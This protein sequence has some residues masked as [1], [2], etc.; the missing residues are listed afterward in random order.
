MAGATWCHPQTML[1]QSIAPAANAPT[2]EIC[3]KHADWRDLLGDDVP[4]DLKRAAGDIYVA[5][6]ALERKL[7]ADKHGFMRGLCA[8]L[9]R[10]GT[11]RYVELHADIFGT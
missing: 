7:G 11:P 2:F 10:R 1:R 8:P 9:I 4:D 5:A 3:A 6:K